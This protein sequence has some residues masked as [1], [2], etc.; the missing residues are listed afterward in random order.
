MIYEIRGKYVMLDSDLA[1]LYKCSNGTKTINQAV[2]RHIN[3]FP[4]RFM[5]Q[6]TNKEYE[7]LWS[8]FGTANYKM[9]RANPYEVSI[10][11]MDAFVEMKKFISSNLIS[12]DYYNKMTIR[13]DDE[14]KLL[15][16]S[17]N[18]LNVRKE[19]DGIFFDG[20]VYDSYSLMLDIFSKAKN[21]IVII[22]NYIEKKY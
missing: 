4:E 20:Q 6:L 18:E 5:F 13:H 8:Q 22:D 2:K 15:Q 7:N 9:S 12:Q 14:I 16:E 3:R 11:I 10:K 21:Y 19:Y 1:R 17:L